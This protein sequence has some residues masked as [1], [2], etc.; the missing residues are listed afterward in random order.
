MALCLLNLLIFIDC[1]L[2]NSYPLFAKFGKNLPRSFFEI[3]KSLKFFEIPKF[4]KG[5]LGKF[6]PNL[7]PLL[8]M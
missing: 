7:P 8:S 2:C 5:K 1:F 3:L 6:I 4:Q